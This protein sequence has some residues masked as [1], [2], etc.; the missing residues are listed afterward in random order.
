[1][2]YLNATGVMKNFAFIGPE[3]PWG[4]GKIGAKMGPSPLV[5]DHYEI[6]ESTPDEDMGRVRNEIVKGVEKIVK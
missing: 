6:A 2:H 5:R 3:R 4:Q 1:M